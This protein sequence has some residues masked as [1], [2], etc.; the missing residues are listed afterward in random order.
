MHIERPVKSKFAT[1]YLF[2]QH[3]QRPLPEQ[4]QQQCQP[5]RLLPEQQL[6]PQ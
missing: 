2:Q 1:L 4:L 3:H 6:Q 5:Q